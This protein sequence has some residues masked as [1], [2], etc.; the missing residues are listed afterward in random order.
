MRRCAFLVVVATGLL[1]PG[2]LAAQEAN[3]D[4]SGH[5]RANGTHDPSKKA[6]RA[7]VEITKNGEVYRLRWKDKNNTWEGVGLR[8]GDRL[9]VATSSGGKSMAVLSYRIIA[10]PNGTRLVGRWAYLSDR[11]TSTETLE[12]VANG[13]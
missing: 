12:P 7:D 5:Y 10:G 3:V 11:I 9:V 1:V 13:K 6:Y 4:I 2:T 8:E